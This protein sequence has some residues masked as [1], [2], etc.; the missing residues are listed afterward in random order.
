MGFH[1]PLRNFSKYEVFLHKFPITSGKNILNMESKFLMTSFI[2]MVPLYILII[3]F[4]H[5]AHSYTQALWFI[6]YG[7]NLSS[8]MK[9]IQR[10]HNGNRVFL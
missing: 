1:Q 3:F 5:G 6:T 4:K 2:F 7:F 10:T 9:E 8:Y